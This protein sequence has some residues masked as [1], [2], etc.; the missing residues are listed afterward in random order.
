MKELIQS[1]G[2][3]GTT[4]TVTV[5]A[6]LPVNGPALAAATALRVFERY[7][8]MD[9]VALVV[10]ATE[11]SMSR[12]QVERVLHPDGFAVLKERGRWRQILARIV[13]GLLA[14]RPA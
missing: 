9:R 7:P 10:G 11:I 3:D 14:E 1:I 12:R 13:Q 4:L 6:T 8:V 5:R 2:L